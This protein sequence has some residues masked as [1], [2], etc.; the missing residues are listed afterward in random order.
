MIACIA[1]SQLLHVDLHEEKPPIAIITR[2]SSSI[3]PEKLKTVSATDDLEGWAREMKF[4]FHSGTYVVLIEKEVL[5]IEASQNRTKLQQVLTAQSKEGKNSFTASDVGDPGIFSS[6]LRNLYSDEMAATLSIGSI[7][8]SPS[9]VLSPTDG[10]PPIVV[11]KS[12]Q[13]IRSLVP[14]TPEPP[15]SNLT[16]SPLVQGGLPPV[17]VQVVRTRLKSE[18]IKA[19]E[20]AFAIM[21][22]LWQRSQKD[23]RKAF[24]DLLGVL[25]EAD[26][27]RSSRFSDLSQNWRDQIVMEIMGRYQDRRVDREVYSPKAIGITFAIRVGNVNYTFGMRYPA[28]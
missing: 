25:G 4:E 1:I 17:K 19:A 14:Q 11:E 7:S 6:L 8:F 21:D 18:Q 3:A 15:V 9:L 12:P 27:S 5:G 22:D 26:L 16:F 2:A 10:T 28:Q 20:S 24:G 23:E 13:F